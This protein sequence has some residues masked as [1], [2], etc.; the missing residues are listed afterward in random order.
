MLFSPILL[1]EAAQALVRSLVFPLLL[2][3]VQNGALLAHVTASLFGRSS[4]GTTLG[5]HLGSA[6]VERNRKNRPP[7]GGLDKDEDGPVCDCGTEQ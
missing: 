4:S 2:G 5:M 1:V 6:L 7:G 3:T